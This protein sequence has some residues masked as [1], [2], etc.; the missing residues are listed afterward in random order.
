MITVTLS[1][2]LL[3]AQDQELILHY[4]RLSESYNSLPSMVYSEMP[5]SKNLYHIDTSQMINY[6]NQLT[7]FYM[8]GVLTERYFQ[9]DYSK[10]R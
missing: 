4:Q 10:L 9:I 1:C 8:V 2:L 5:F 6:A 3:Y 7:S